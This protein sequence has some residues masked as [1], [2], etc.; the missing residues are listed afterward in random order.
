LGFKRKFA[1]EQLRAIRHAV[2][3]WSLLPKEKREPMTLTE[4]ARRLGISLA[5]ASRIRHEC[6][7]LDYLREVNDEA[8]AYQEQIER[9]VV[10]Q[11]ISGDPRA[12]KLYQAYLAPK[13][14]D[15]YKSYTKRMRRCGSR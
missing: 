13:E 14:D 8:I 11:A 1:I 3:R 4:L 5:Y 12:I 9:K 6:S 7:V 15:T 10:N 2:I